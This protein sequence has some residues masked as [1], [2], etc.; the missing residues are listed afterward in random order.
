VLNRI[1]VF[2]HGLD[3]RSHVHEVWTYTDDSDNF[4]TGC[5]LV[6]NIFF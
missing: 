5:I 4:H 6:F 2:I 3:A 1:K